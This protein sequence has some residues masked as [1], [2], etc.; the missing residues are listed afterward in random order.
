MLTAIKQHYNIA[1]VAEVTPISFRFYRYNY[2]IF[3]DDWLWALQSENGQIEI[4]DNQGVCIN[5]INC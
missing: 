5:V 2:Q 1:H 3:T 4:Y